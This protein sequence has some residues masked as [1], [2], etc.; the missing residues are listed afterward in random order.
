MPSPT[1]PIPGWRAGRWR[2]DPRH[3]TV[4]FRV[5]LLGVSPVRGV[6]SRFEI[7]AATG[8][9]LTDTWARA[10]VEADSIRTGDPARD[11]EHRAADVF[12]AAAFPTVVFESSGVTADEGGIRMDGTLALRGVRRPVAFEVEIGGVVVDD[13]G[14]VRLGLEARGTI[15]R[16]DFGV[17]WAAADAAG[18]LLLGDRVALLLDAELV[19]E[20]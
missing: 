9:R 6:F 16:R 10:V 2:A 7:E 4:G 20:D 17:R 3:T 12:W 1:D 8:D 19:L 11:A 13:A 14:E 5:R 15:D 18:R